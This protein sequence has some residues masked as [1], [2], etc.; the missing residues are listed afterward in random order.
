MHLVDNWSSC[1]SLYLLPLLAEETQLD[2]N[3]CPRLHPDLQFGRY[4]VVDA[5]RLLNRGW[6]IIYDM[7]NWSKMKRRILIGSLSGQNFSIRTAR[8]GPLTN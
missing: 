4:D 6:T 1:W 7:T 3:S 2:G 5:L 8:D